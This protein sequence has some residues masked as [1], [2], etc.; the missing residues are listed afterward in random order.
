MIAC[1]L[2]LIKSVGGLPFCDLLINLMII[3]SSLRLVRFLGEL[4]FLSI[5]KMMVPTRFNNVSPCQGTEC[6]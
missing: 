2:V 3:K 6:P 1:L 5:Q 4:A